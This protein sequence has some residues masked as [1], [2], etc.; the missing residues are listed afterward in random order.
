ML[1]TGLDTEFDYSPFLEKATQQVQKFIKNKSLK[2]EYLPYIMSAYGAA[3]DK[4]E[5]ADTILE[6]LEDYAL[7]N[8]QQL[9]AQQTANLII[10][11]GDIIHSAELVEICEKIIAANIDEL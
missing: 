3:A 8:F 10:M 4:I 6:M 9:T 2:L 7:D 5:G 1:M 11:N